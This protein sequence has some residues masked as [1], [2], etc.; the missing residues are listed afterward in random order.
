MKCPREMILHPMKTQSLLPTRVRRTLRVKKRM[1][2][3]QNA[4]PSRR[5]RQRLFHLLL[6]TQDEEAAELAKALMSKKAACLYG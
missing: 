3:W 1:T 2:Q 4:R 6:T 5:S